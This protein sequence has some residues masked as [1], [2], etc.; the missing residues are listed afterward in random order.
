MFHF[1]SEDKN[2]LGFVS[3]TSTKA[4][5]SNALILVPGLTDGFMSLD[6]TEHLSSE[7][8]KI[9]YSLVQVNLS[10]S[11]YQF[12]VCSLQ[13]DCR[14]LTQ[15]VKYIKKEYNFKNI[16]FLGHSTGAQDALF[17]VGHSEM[18][19][20]IDGF[21]LQGAVSDRDV[22]STMES[23]PRMLEEAHRLKAD[24]K[25]DSVLSEKF[26]GAVITARR[27]LS[28]AERLGEDDMFSIDLTKE[29]MKQI[30][31][32]VQVPI[33]L[34]YSAEDE[35]VP[36]KEGQR[37][38]ATRLDDTLKLT[39]PKVYMKYFSG[40]H[41]LSKPEYY[42]PFVEYVCNFVSMLK[43]ISSCVASHSP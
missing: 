35:Y 32:Q 24:G 27:Y 23:T 4:V 21:I 36:D 18:S 33:A 8:L 15:L 14:E 7:L 6:Y 20:L 43:E 1:S 22:I 31:P 10:S 12:G 37:Q 30:I 42:S 3:L 16:V 34:C 9:E 29:E 26:E 2:L 28:L 41:G 17:F 40:D 5:C 25:L 39:S 11:F 38:M 13:S 19:E